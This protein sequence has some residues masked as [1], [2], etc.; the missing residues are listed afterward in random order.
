[1]EEIVTT[2]CEA[3]SSS[4]K[5]KE[6]SQQFSALTSNEQ[7]VRF[8][9]SLGEPSRLARAVFVPSLVKDTARSQLSRNE[10]NRCYARGDNASALRLYTEAVSAAPSRSGASSYDDT[11]HISLAYAN[12]SAALLR[13]D[14]AVCSLLDVK[15][16]LLAGCPS[17]TREKLLRRLRDI[18][19]VAKKKHVQLPSDWRSQ[20]GFCRS[21]CL[22][23]CP[24]LTLK[25]PS[26]TDEYLIDT[27]EEV[28]ISGSLKSTTSTEL[29]AGVEKSFSPVKIAGHQRIDAKQIT[30]V[31]EK[32]SDQLLYIAG[33]FAAQ[34]CPQLENYNF[35]LPSA[36]DKIQLAFSEDRTRHIVAAED[37]EPGEV[38]V[39]ESGYS[40]VILPDATAL[41][42]I[43]STCHY[44]CRWS[45]APVPC[46]SCCQVLYCSEE[47]CH[48]AWQRYHRLECPIWNTLFSLKLDQMA[49]LAFRTLTVSQWERASGRSDEEKEVEGSAGST[50]TLNE[51]DRGSF[52]RIRRL[53]SHR[54]QRSAG[55]LFRRTIIATVL[56]RILCPLLSASSSP[57]GD[58]NVLGDDSE[59][60]ATLVGVCTELVLLLQTLPC[61]AHQVCDQQ[62]PPFLGDNDSATAKCRM[63]EAALVQTGSSVYPTMSLLNHSCWPNVFRVNHGS[64][65]VLY[66]LRRIRRGQEL[67]DNYGQ[68]YALTPR[69]QRQHALSRQYYFNCTCQACVEDTPLYGDLPT[70]CAQCRHCERSVAPSNDQRIISGSGGV[71]GHC[72]CYETGED[73]VA[74][75]LT[76]TCHLMSE[77]VQQ[78][79][80]GQLNGAKNT[81]V[82]CIASV[83]DD[84]MLPL[85]PINDAQEALKLCCLIDGNKSPL[86]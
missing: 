26:N 46:S 2:V 78:V 84:V 40:T 56:G 17:K 58:P 29:Q 4:G 9:L 27:S 64:T 63:S 85:Q 69:M 19:E 77:C 62:L 83:E 59:D 20:L 57:G 44:C 16:A 18:E 36:S 38:L 73:G 81:L 51:G 55:D 14:H 48:S 42:Q 53:E 34:P 79:M 5:T 31:T 49:L 41:R 60:S 54:N 28:E 76:D 65:A 50:I 82:Q 22:E 7:R 80:R 68:H 67:L 3:I 35:K 75:T 47:C 45:P 6:L 8:F 86:I 11:H 21:L 30:H 72:T 39:V 66:S 61:N 70:G 24:N 52:E 12:R 10:G 23:S 37:I 25:K 33:E 1:M 32:T 13:L 71:H 15:R 43:G 74:H